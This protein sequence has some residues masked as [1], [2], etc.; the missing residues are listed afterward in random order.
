MRIKFLVFVFFLIFSAS[1]SNAQQIKGAVL[2]GFNLTQVDGDEVYGFKRFGLNI[3]VSAILPLGDKWAL[4]LENSFSQKGA[5][6]KEQYHLDDTARP[7]T[8]EYNLRL[9]YVEIPILLHFSDKGGITFGAGFSYSRLVGSKEI[10]HGKDTIS[11]ANKYPFKDDDFSV[12]A[13]IRFRIWKRLQGN[14]RYSYS[15]GSIRERIFY[16]TSGQNSWVRK[17]FNNTITFRVIY[18][19]N[20][21]L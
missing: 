1:Q 14:F 3:G 7:F 12:I 16:D 21:K 6:Q 8:G 20:E 11:Y 5:Y 4:S 19:F 2:G 15:L 9:N 13:D 10:E 17:Q 18:V